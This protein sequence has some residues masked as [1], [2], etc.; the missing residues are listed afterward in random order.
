MIFKEK[1]TTHKVIYS[2]I[3]LLVVLV[4]SIAFAGCS[5]GATENTTPGYI[6]ETLTKRGIDFSFEYPDDYEKNEYIQD[7]DSDESDYVVLQYYASTDY[8]VNRKIINIQI[9]NPMEDGQDARTKLDHYAANLEFTG[10]DPVV[11]ERSPL[12]VAGIDAEKMVF[13]MVVEDITDIPNKLTGW[14]AAFDYKGQIWFIVV[15][16]NMEATDEVEADFEHLIE[17]FK[18]LD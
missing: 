8:D 18:F 6:T 11:H 14:I 12:Q 10:T 16:T 2:V 3:L 1:I 9:W 17:S 7:D 15:T 13:S 4:V 5:S